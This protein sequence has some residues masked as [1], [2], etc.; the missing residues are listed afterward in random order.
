MLWR[1]CHFII[2]KMPGLNCSLEKNKKLLECKVRP[3][4]LFGYFGGKTR[5]ADK[6]IS[7]FPEHHT[8]VE[9]FV[10]GGSVYFA[11]TIPDKFVIND[12]DK[13]LIGVYKDAKHNPHKIESCELNNMDKDK[14]N[15]IKHKPSHNTCD[16]LRLT[17]HSF[18]TQGPHASYAHKN[19][20]YNNVQVTPIHKKKLNKTLILNQDFKK[21]AKDYDK[22]GVLQ[23]LDP[24]YFKQGDAYRHHGVTPEEVCSTAKSLKKA[25]VVISY[26]NHPRV[27]QACK[28][29]KIKN[30]YVPYSAS[31]LSKGKKELLITN[32]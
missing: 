32:F 17:K 20:H 10:G 28:G 11:N 19:R 21:V 18:G 31:G 3:K 14:F 25:K 24:P 8:Y 12:L 2:L 30:L 7:T 23:Y 22:P 5:V 15:K 13:E 16:F 1:E 27:K 6:I 29:L 4:S 9:P 26:D